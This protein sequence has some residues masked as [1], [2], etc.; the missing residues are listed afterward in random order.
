MNEEKKGKTCV[1]NMQEND[2]IIEKFIKEY[3]QE[4]ESVGE[5]L[6]SHKTDLIVNFD[7]SY[8][9]GQN[10]SFTCGSESSV[11]SATG[12]GYIEPK[13]NAEE[14]KSYY[15]DSDINITIEEVNNCTLDQTP[16]EI[17]KWENCQDEW[18]ECNRSGWNTSKNTKESNGDIR[19]K[20]SVYSTLLSK[21]GNRIKGIKINLYKLNGISSELQESKVTDGD[22]CVVFNNIP[23]GSYRVIQIIDKKFFEKPCYKSWNEVTISSENTET[24]I[25]AINNVKPQF[26]KSGEKY[27]K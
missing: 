5:A 19:G 9:D 21:E 17:K 25:F 18:N 27:C 12:K 6:D 14:L 8:D 3:L 15:G 26:I 4:K 10:K 24:E 20:I 11:F 23:E 22:G 7:I 2:P 1:T 13:I 16:L